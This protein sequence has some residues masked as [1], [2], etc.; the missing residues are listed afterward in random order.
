M[1][2]FSKAISNCFKKSFSIKGRATRAEYWW[3]QLFCL[4]IDIVILIPAFLF[5]VEDVIQVCVTLIGIRILIC[6]IP[7]IC[8]TIRRLHDVGM[9]A[10]F[11]L[12]VFIPFGGFILLFFL[13]SPSAFDNQF[14]PNPHEHEYNTEVEEINL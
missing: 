11:I 1:V 4:L 13:L 5:K 14:G 8:L 3:F 10:W 9:S 6:L 2:S 7:N 12:I